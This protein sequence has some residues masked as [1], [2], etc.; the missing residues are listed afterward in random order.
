MT[1]VPATHGTIILSNLITPSF[2][3]LP[4][5][6]VGPP[7]RAH[8]IQWITRHMM[9]NTIVRGIPK[10]TF[11]WQAQSRLANRCQ[12]LL[13]GYLLILLTVTAGA[14]PPIEA[15]QRAVQERYLAIHGVPA[16]F[17][18]R[19]VPDNADPGDFPPDGF[20]QSGN[21]I[22]QA[23]SSVRG[24]L[25][26]VEY[27]DNFGN[28]SGL[29]W[30]YSVL[31]SLEDLHLQDPMFWGSSASVFWID[32]SNYMHGV[33]PP[34]PLASQPAVLSRFQEALC[35]MHRFVKICPTSGEFRY[36]TSQS[37]YDCAD[38]YSDALVRWGDPG[39]AWLPYPFQYPL[40]DGV[41]THGKG[42]GVSESLAVCSVGCQ[43]LECDVSE[44][45]G[46]GR[47][48]ALLTQLGTAAIDAPL[49]VD[50][51]F[52]FLESFGGRQV[53]Q[54][55]E[56]PSRTPITYAPLADCGAVGWYVTQTAALF[57]A[58]FKD[59]WLKYDGASCTG[60]CDGC[61]SDGLCDEF[62]LGSVRVKLGLGRD[63]FGGGSVALRLEA[64]QPF[65]GLCTPGMLGLKSTWDAEVIRAGTGCRQVVTARLAADIVTIS[66]HC[67]EVR[68]YPLTRLGAKVNGIYEFTGAPLRVTRFE[69]PVEGGAV[70]YKKLVITATKDGQTVVHEF[71]QDPSTGQLKLT[72]GPGLREER[73]SITRTANSR[74]ETRTVHDPATGAVVE[75]TVRVYGI[76]PWGQPLVTE[77]VDPD[78]RALAT[79]YEYYT[80]GT[81][82][83]RVGKL[84]SKIDP[85]GHWETYEYDPYGRETKRVVQFLDY[86]VGAPDSSSR[87]F[88]TAYSYPGGASLEHHTET[89]LGEIVTRS[90]KKTV[91]D[92]V[93]DIVCTSPNA[94]G[95]DDPGNLVTIT[96]C[97]GRG[98][99]TEGAAIGR[100]ASIRRPDGTVTTYRY[101]YGSNGLYGAYRVTTTA[102]G[103]PNSGTDDT[104]VDGRE[105]EVWVNEAG[106]EVK[107]VVRVIQSSTTKV[108]VDSMQVTALDDFGF[109]TTME[110][111][112]GSVETQSSGCCG[113]LITHT[114][115]LGITTERT[116]DGLGRVVSEKR[117]GITIWSTYDA[118]GRVVK[119]EREGTDHSMMTQYEAAYDASGFRL[120]E[121]DAV[122]RQT[123]FDR[124]LWENLDG[125]I[126]GYWDETEKPNGGY[127]I[128]TYASDGSLLEV[129]GTAS[130]PRFYDYGVGGYYSF[131][132][133]GPGETFTAERKCAS[134]C[135]DWVVLTIRDMAG[136]VVRTEYEDG[137]IDYND[138][139]TKG[140]LWRRVDADGV[141]TMFGFNAR[142]EQDLTAIDMK[143][144]GGSRNGQIDLNGVD[145]ITRTYA[146]VATDS[147]SVVERRT[148]TELQTPNSDLE[149]AV[150]V[151]DRLVASME[152]RDTRNGLTTRRTTVLGSNESRTETVVAPDG[153][154]NIRRYTGTR[155]TEEQRLDSL[156]GQITRQLHFYDAHGRRERTEDARDGTTNFTYYNDDSIETV[157]T[158]PPQAG[159]NRL[160][161][162][163]VYTSMGE[164]KE[165]HH[166]DGSSVTTYEYWLTGDLKSVGGSGEY[167]RT[168]TYD[169]EGRIKT[170]T[171]ARGSVSWTY[172]A[173][174]GFLAKKSFADGSHVDYGYTLAGRL[175]TRAWARG[176]TTTYGYN[177][178]GDLT[179]T[180]YSDST[181][182]VTVTYSRRG[183][184]DTILDGCGT[185]QLTHDAAG[186][187]LNE[188]FVAGAYAGKWTV[189]RSPDAYLRRGSLQVSTPWGLVSSLAYGYDK[190][191]RLETLTDDAN[192]KVLFV[193]TPNS[194]LVSDAIY[195]VVGVEVARQ[196]TAHDNL[197]RIT[198]TYG[199]RSGSTVGTAYAYTYDSLGRRTRVDMTGQYWQYGYNARNEVQSGERRLT[200]GTLLAQMQYYYDDIGNRLSTLVNGRTASYQPNALSQY[201]SR[202]VPGAVDVYGEATANAVLV[203]G[204]SAAQ[205]GNLFRGTVPVDNGAAPKYPDITVRATTTQGAASETG[206]HVFVPKTPEAF[207]HDTDGNL[208]ADGRW[209]YTWDGENRLTAMT[210]LA[211]VPPAAQRRLAFYYDYMSRRVRKQEFTRNPATEQLD[212]PAG[213][214]FYAWDGWTLVAELAAD[215]SPV[216]RYLWNTAKGHKSLAAARLG[217]GT[218]AASPPA[219]FAIVDGNDNVMRL[220][221][222]ATPAGSAAEVTAV[223]EYGPFGEPLR[224]TGPAADANPVR[225]S[226]ETVDAASGFY[227]YGYRYYNPDTGRWLSRDPAF[228][229]A[230]W[231]QASS[232]H[233][234][235]E[236]SHSERESNTYA[237]VGNSP[238]LFPDF[239]GLT[240]FINCC[241][242]DESAI[243]AARVSS[244]IRITMA[245]DSL[246]LYDWKTLTMDYPKAR[247]VGLNNTDRYRTQR[248]AL[249][250]DFSLFKLNLEAVLSDMVAG[251]KANNVPLRCAPASEGR[252]LSGDTAY[253][254]VSPVFNGIGPISFCPVFF[255]GTNTT[256]PNATFAHEMSHYFEGTHD[257][258]LMPTPVLGPPWREYYFHAEPYK[259][260]YIEQLADDPK[261]WKETVRSMVDTYLP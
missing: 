204:I 113:G 68:R 228:E 64:E 12:T 165:V 210:T 227:Y 209:T 133:A 192:N 126:I 88:T 230:F 31:C 61:G 194:D 212:V 2:S 111:K 51:K 4:D 164:T 150:G 202:T 188:Q 154:Q 106:T 95:P 256:T 203:N 159:Q 70:N 25:W 162:S 181:P 132:G 27:G 140:Q 18:S 172:S 36:V 96:K 135:I 53:A 171:L 139:N 244:G 62:E 117:D 249:Y 195:S 80:D 17:P 123:S 34:D 101:T 131:F 239:L 78:G 23:Y 110:H 137:A 55:C 10:T 50:D 166:P 91:G 214:A 241:P 225:F 175:Q 77:I 196:V 76:Y 201:A 199:M 168:M 92:S 5:A 83:A 24:I 170:L 161:T 94:T 176:V 28:E 190:A 3:N 141:V 224:V 112:D 102:E 258:L 41:V 79:E 103:K 97:Y 257:A 38:H 7:K 60:E 35:A 40:E 125:D 261:L 56:F 145:R 232:V 45:S 58:D 215:G 184:A 207:T 250:R 226:S 100:T 99:S 179:T 182:D 6:H 124:H 93:F 260:Y 157:T 186:L 9:L 247:F 87:V 115:R 143:P 127:V 72:Q 26:P 107:R 156:G 259:A 130:R 248:H 253:C 233:D 223:Y 246:E 122:G 155:L 104:V 129:S 243:E 54:S 33:Q 114:D 84:K 254:A 153:S 245:L 85:Y 219:Q 32:G 234:L 151:S 142:G 191:S 46:C 167:P 59:D 160:V 206:G 218:G 183:L 22:D 11:N 231:R 148:T 185:R 44:A 71:S 134:T 252:C 42:F 216:R 105:T 147:G 74:T 29:T 21:D 1:I 82:A 39:T 240:T 57:T 89:L 177:E 187:P 8:A 49:P 205:I 163:Y 136:R 52:H 13:A 149:V 200:A 20:Y 251:Y 174:R 66:D 220:V 193:R 255:S 152:S 118:A 119:R 19:T 242:A 69:N 217:T 213:D 43:S 16:N 116:E 221:N 128:Q 120:W 48:Y 15:I 81:P 146:S 208:T 198:N 138:Y 189:S 30:H 236:G 180:D 211:S 197:D 229:M 173:E 108:E 86:L 73:L 144:S 158:P 14:A 238:T 37:G 47:F 90:Y 121:K 98:D 178:A 222:G 235:M 109:P 67:F 169:E 65:E 237:C 63:G 75:K